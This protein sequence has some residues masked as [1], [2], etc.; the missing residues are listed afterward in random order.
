MRQLGKE[1]FNPFQVQMQQ[2][3]EDLRNKGNELLKS[4]PVGANMATAFWMMLK[5]LDLALLKKF[6]TL[7]DPAEKR[8]DMQ[9]L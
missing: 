2:A 5:P 8:L 6:W 4:V 3:T 9:G 1:T 7:V